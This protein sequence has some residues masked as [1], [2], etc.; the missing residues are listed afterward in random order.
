MR[1]LREP[2][3][4]GASI[5]HSHPVREDCGGLA[6]RVV[7]RVLAHEALIVAHALPRARGVLQVVRVGGVGEVERVDGD[8]EGEDD[9]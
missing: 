7:L 2:R 4:I 3:E 1:V 8:A 6:R 5:N 9:A